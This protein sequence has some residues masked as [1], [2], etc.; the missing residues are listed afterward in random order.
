M[1]CIVSSHLI[2]HT[3]IPECHLQYLVELT[4]ELI[5]SNPNAIQVGNVIS[6]RN[7]DRQPGLQPVK[8][9][10]YSM[11]MYMYMYIYIYI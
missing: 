5:K 10:V 3:P 2:S 9:S 8:D 4:G 6:F 11:Y 1:L 7:I